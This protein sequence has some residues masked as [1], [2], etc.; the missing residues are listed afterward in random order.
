MGSDL[1]FYNNMSF[2]PKDM[3]RCEGALFRDRRISLSE[4]EILPG[5]AQPGQVSAKP[6]QDDMVSTTKQYGRYLN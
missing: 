6:S 2:P 5:A 3:G 1:V 4:V